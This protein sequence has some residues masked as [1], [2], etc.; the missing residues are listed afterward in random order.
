M[1]PHQTVTTVL[2]GRRSN[3]LENL[4]GR[5]DGKTEDSFS[6]TS[7]AVR[8]YE[9]HPVLKLGKGKLYGGCARTPKVKDADCMWCCSLVT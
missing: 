3:V 5:K 7:M 1:F 4:G 8:C 9:S 2:K 6:G